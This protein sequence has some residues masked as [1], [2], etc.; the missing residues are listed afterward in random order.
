MA[1]TQNPVEGPIT[2]EVRGESLLAVCF[3]AMASPCE[4]LLTGDSRS[5]AMYAGMLAA[6]EAWRVE[7]KYSR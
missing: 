7:K 6:Q 4:V 1:G 5:E 3:R 2:I